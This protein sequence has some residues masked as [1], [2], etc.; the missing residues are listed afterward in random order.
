MYL[1]KLHINIAPYDKNL[2]RGRRE[3]EKVRRPGCRRPIL[4]LD[5]GDS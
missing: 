3:E 5:P 4:T 2:E 1:S